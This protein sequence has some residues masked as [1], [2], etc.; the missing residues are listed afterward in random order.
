MKLSV[1][2]PAYNDL[3]AVMRCVQSVRDTT[4]PHRTEVLVQD[5]CSPN[6]NMPP[7]LG[8]MCKRNAE[9]LGFPGNCN[10]GAA[11]ARGDVILLLN[12]DIWIAQRGWDVRL[13][14]FFELTPRAGIAGP[15]LLFP[16]GSVQSV[17]GGFDGACHPYH[18]ALGAANP[19]W[20]PIATPREVAWITGAA[21]A[22]RASIWHDLGGFDTGYIGGYFEDVDFCL[23]A[24]QAGHTVWHRPNIRM[25]HG[26]GSTGG[27]PHFMHNAM[28]FKAR[29]VDTKIVKP[30]IGSLKEGWWA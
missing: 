29:W 18:I 5:D 30:E 24:R 13:L 15:T 19:D 2:I 28:R 14:D 9:N 7:L 21:F 25:F 1:I 11:R 22:V 27:N 26:V 12:H 10:A 17:G 16:D 20:E 8:P 23:R 4:N 6:V 3:E